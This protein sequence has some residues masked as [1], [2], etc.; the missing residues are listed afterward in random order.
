MIRYSIYGFIFNATI[1]GYDLEGAV[2]NFVSFVCP[3]GEVILATIKSEDDTRLRLKALEEKYPNFKVVESNIDISKTNKWDGLLKTEALNACSN[4]LRIIADIDERFIVKSRSKW[5]SW[6]Q[7]LLNNSR[8]DGVL[9]P[10]IDLFGSPDKIRA[11]QQIGQKFRL[12]KK[13]VYARGVPNFADTGNG[14]IRTDLSDTSDPIDFNGNLCKFASVVNPAFLLPQFA[15]M[16]ENVPYVVHFGFCDLQWRADL[17]KNFWL[18]HWTKRS[19]HQEN[20]ATEISQLNQHPVC[21]HNL[22]IQ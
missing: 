8:L 1:R 16:L 14:L 18:D 4:E 21:F 6:A 22:P 20:V 13:S 9:V 10:V 3:E 7:T 19:G 12:H 17:G 15:D 11:D 2:D 5:D